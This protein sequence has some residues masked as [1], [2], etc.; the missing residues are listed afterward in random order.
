MSGKSPGDRDDNSNKQVPNDSG[1][2]ILEDWPDWG[3]PDSSSTQSQ[4]PESSISEAKELCGASGPDSWDPNGLSEVAV[5]SR[6]ADALE[7]RAAPSLALDPSPAHTKPPRASRPEKRPQG[8]TQLGLG[9]E[10]TIQV[11]ATPAEPELDWFADMVPEI[12]PSAL[13]PE[14][15]DGQAWPPAQLSSKFAAAD[16]PEV[17]GHLFGWGW[18]GG[19]WGL[20]RCT[21]ASSLAAG[22][23]RRLGRRWGACLGR[24]KLVTGSDPLNSANKYLSRLKQDQSK[25]PPLS[26]GQAGAAGRGALLQEPRE[27]I[28]TKSS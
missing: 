10:F 15:I 28:N 1:T 16:M 2:R 7:Q 21:P 6:G 3:E 5:T 9:E 19:H 23:G 27:G 14:P 11:R 4:P 22:R 20:S 17:S 12:K 25:W 13:F 18:A 24:D 26:L 8:P